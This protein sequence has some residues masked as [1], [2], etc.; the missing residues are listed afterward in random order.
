MTSMFDHDDSVNLAFDAKIAG[1]HLVTAK[2]D[3][4][5]QTGDFLFLAHSDRELALRMQ[6]IEKDIENV[7]YRR[8]ASV[9]DSKAKLVRAVYDEWQLRHAKCEMCKTALSGAGEIQPPE[10]KNKALNHDTKRIFHAPEPS[11]KKA[12]I[13][14]GKTTLDTYHGAPLCKGGICISGQAPVSN[15]N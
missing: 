1:K 15:P 10:D 2:H 12:C 14:C 9:S 3:L 11:S 13:N 7:A 5:A 4:L 8:L 6:M